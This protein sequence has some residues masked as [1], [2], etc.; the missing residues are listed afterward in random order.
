M[1]ILIMSANASGIVGSQLFQAGDAPKYQT[2]WSAILGLVAV[3][4]VCSAIANVQYWLL[5]RRD[6]RKGLK[7]KYKY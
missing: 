5:N 7:M 3:A 6:A 1:A 4:V 2:G